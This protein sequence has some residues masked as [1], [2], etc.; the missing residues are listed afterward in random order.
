VTAGYVDLSTEH[1]AECQERVSRFLMKH[2]KGAPTPKK[3][4][5]KSERHL[6]AV[7]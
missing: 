7:A 5:K 2:I 4:T 1:L 6:K 3:K